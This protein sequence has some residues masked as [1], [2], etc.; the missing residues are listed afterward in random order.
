V[1]QVEQEKEKR[2]LLSPF[3]IVVLVAFQATLVFTVQEE[4]SA[5]VSSGTTTSHACTA[6]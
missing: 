1:N 4:C 6:G 3:F 2:C 5:P